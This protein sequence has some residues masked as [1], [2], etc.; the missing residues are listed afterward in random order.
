MEYFIYIFLIIVFVWMAYGESRRQLHMAQLEGYKPDQY[1]N[2]IKHNKTTIFAKRYVRILTKSDKTNNIKKTL[3]FTS[4]AKR[5]FVV[6]FIFLAIWLVFSFW[7]A[8]NRLL[9]LILFLSVT[10]VLMPVHMLLSTIVVYP[11]EMTIQRKYYIEAQN[12]I[13]SMRKLI[14]IGITGSYGKTSTK[15]FL[16]TILSEKYHTLM[17]PESYNT[18]MGITKIIREQLNDQHEVFVCEM[19]ARNIGD[20]KELGELVNPSIGIIVSIG[21]QHLETFKTI[22]NIANTKYELIELLP[23]NGMAIFNGDNPYC[24]KLA[25][26]THIKKFLYSTNNYNKNVYVY[27]ENIIITEK[28]L[29]FSIISN[30]GHSFECQTALLGKH[31]VNNILAAVCV[32]F[33]LGF[34]IEQIQNGIT[35]LRPVPHRLELIYSSN[36]VVVIDDAFNSNPAGAKEALETI[37]E[38]TKGNRIIIT[39]GMVELGEIEADENRKFGKMIAECCDYAILIGLK[40]SRPIVEGLMEG[41]FPKNRIIVT[42]S[43][44]EATTKMTEII[45]AGDTVLFENDLPDHYNE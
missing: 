43:L 37:K 34:T 19:G 27:A 38:F 45:K 3:V 9:L 17:T 8:N 15:Y 16:N 4:R 18:P 21:S 26:K 41:Y 44:N 32:A 33:S 11:M 24:V 28:G 7:L 40:R 1:F 23:A 10:I 35:K 14:V 6:N 20:I 13:R 39:P 5:L 25:E 36:G 22:E 30:G 12:K 2:W 29:K 42:T 31:N